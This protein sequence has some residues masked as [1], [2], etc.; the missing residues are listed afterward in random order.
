MI[1]ALKLA[2]PGIDVTYYGSEIGMSN[3]YVRA[4]QRQDP[5]NAGGIKID[6]TRDG[7]RCPMQ[8]DD[9]INAGKTSHNSKYF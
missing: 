5:N 1:T 8:W 3:A 2:L 7:G 9:S 6:E 4:D